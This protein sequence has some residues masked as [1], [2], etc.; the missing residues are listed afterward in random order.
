[1]T[2][3]EQNEAV[4]KLPVRVESGRVLDVCGRV[5]CKCSNGGNRGFDETKATDARRAQEAHAIAHALNSQGKLVTLVG[6]LMETIRLHMRCTCAPSKHA[7]LC[8]RC[9]A[10]QG[11]KEV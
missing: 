9:S 11:A 5:I 4:I 6:S 8:P 7:N 10:I 3:T 1:M 2:T